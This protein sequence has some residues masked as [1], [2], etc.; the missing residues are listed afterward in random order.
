M[1]E[2]TTRFHENAIRLLKGLIKA[3]EGWVNYEK[4]NI[5]SSHK[6]TV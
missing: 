4:K 5:K 6:A 1:T 2:N 3:Y